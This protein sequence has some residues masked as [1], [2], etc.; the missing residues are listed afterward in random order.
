MHRTLQWFKLPAHEICR[1][2]YFSYSPVSAL[3]ITS[4]VSV[5]SFLPGT[6]KGG[7]G[8]LN[9][10]CQNSNGPFGSSVIH[11]SWVNS[12]QLCPPID[13]QLQAKGQHVG[14]LF[15]PLKED[16]QQNNLPQLE[17]QYISGSLFYHAQ[18]LLSETPDKWEN[19]GDLN[20][21]LKSQRFIFIDI[22]A[23]FFTSLWVRK[24]FET[25]WQMNFSFIC[26]LL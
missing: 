15:S 19:T 1:L 14:L 10:A 5:K 7:I 22:S 2:M 24:W 13:Y 8:F 25:P 16:C 6:I 21:C 18:K 20:T 23:L 9:P 11:L 4:I 3:C 17:S 26:Q 12:W